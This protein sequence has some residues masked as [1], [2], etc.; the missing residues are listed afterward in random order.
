MRSAKLQEKRLTLEAFAG[1]DG[2]V[3]LFVRRQFDL[4][5]RFGLEE[6][7]SL[8]FPRKMARFEGS[9][10]EAALPSARQSAKPNALIQKISSNQLLYLPPG[11][12][13]QLSAKTKCSKVCVLKPA[14]EFWN[15]CLLENHLTLQESKQSFSK[16]VTLT[17][18]RWMDDLIDRYD[19]E[20]RLNTRTPAQCPS[21]LEK[22]IF[23][24]FVRLMLP[25]KVPTTGKLL[26]SEEP[27]HI[28]KAVAFIESSLFE[29]VQ[30]ADIARA[31]GLQESAFLKGFVEQC[32]MTPIAYLQEVRLNFAASSLER[33]E[34]T[35]SDLAILCQFS[36]LS[37]FS[38]AFKRKFGSSPK[39]FQLGFR[40]K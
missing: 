27:T 39:D 3:E 22:Q 9:I 31:S 37:S 11:F 4:E 5:L 14:N 2:D 13:A 26:G 36:E 7:I 20:R 15:R 35:P 6:K 17:L 25:G 29:E 33:G 23:N 10:W 19:F 40:S 38:R 16:P 32:G 21:F 8:I 34:Y 24:E 1:V 30:L 18:S 12:G 28:S